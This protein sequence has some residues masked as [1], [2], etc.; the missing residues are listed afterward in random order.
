MVT[1]L[2]DDSARLF[3]RVIVQVSEAIDTCDAI[4]AGAAACHLQLGL[5]L[6]KQMI[7]LPPDPE[8]Q[9]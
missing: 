9:Q 3:H 8:G 7:K 6:L 2:D 5:D 1:D 4:G